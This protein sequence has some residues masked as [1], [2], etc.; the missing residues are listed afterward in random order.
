M[1]AALRALSRENPRF[2]AWS[3]YRLAGL[4]QKDLLPDVVEVLTAPDVEFGLR[5][6]VLQALEG[7]TL[8]SELSEILTSMVVDATA[9]FATRSEAGE[10]LAG[11]DLG[12]DWSGIV[13][14]LGAQNT[15]D[16]VRLASELMDDVGFDRFSDAQILAVSLSM[17]SQS[18]RAVGVYAGLQ[19]NLPDGRIDA[20]L[21]GIA[22]AAMDMEDRRARPG[23]SAITDLAFGLLARRLA[24]GQLD[25]ETVWTWM[26]PF[27]NGGSMYRQSRKTVAELLAS[28]APL[29]Q[30][31][32]RHVLLD[33]PGDKNVWQRA[34]RLNERSVG[35]NP[36]E[37]DILALLEALTDDDPRWRDVVRLAAHSDDKGETVRAA[38]ARFV[39]GDPEG[40]SWLVELPHPEVP[41]WEL[42]EQTRRRARERKRDADWA[43]HRADFTKGI[44]ALRR[45][46]YGLT[47]GPAKAYLKLFYDMGDDAT[48]GPGRLEEWLGPEIRDACL[49]GFEAFLLLTPPKPT[50]TEIAASYAENRRWEAGYIIT[51]ALG[52]RLRTGRGFDDL[53]DERLMAGLFEVRHTR[54]DD[55]AGLKGLDTELVTIVRRRGIWE[56]AQRLYFETQ[57][58]K[59]R[60]HVDGLYALMRDAADAPLATA[61]AIEWLDRFPAMSSETELELLDHLLSTPKGRDALSLLVPLRLDLDGLDPDR[62]KTWETIGLILRFE[63]TRAALEGSEA[64]TPDHFWHL[65]AR[66]RNDRD[67][68]PPPRLTAGQLA[69]MIGT[70]RTLLPLWHRPEGVTSGDDNE[71]DASEFI[72]ALVNRLG[73]DVSSEAMEGLAALRDGPEDGYT[74]TLRVAAAEQRRKRVEADWSPPDLATI[75]TTVSDE[76]PT[77][78]PQLQAILL[79]ELEVIQAELQG[80]D[81]DWYRDFY[82]GAAPRKEDDC[83]NSILKMLRPLPFDIQAAP[84]GHLADDKRADIMCTLGDLMVPIEVK[85]QWHPELW[86]AADKQLDRLYVNDWRAERGIYLVLWFGP[87]A[88]KRPMPPPAGVPP[89]QTPQALQAALT[90]QSATTRE[91]RN[92]VV[93]LDLT[94]PG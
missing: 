18:D 10:R 94:R 14:Q 26:R 59:G 34:W 25:A 55:H 56:A 75:A 57:V 73:D 13:D 9:V 37:D 11:L 74:D 24:M 43:K 92:Q 51:A 53:T 23:Y 79:E 88:S 49:E 27:D 44:E 47:L 58:S 7:S 3:R 45:G 66:L 89:P 38:A 83:R 72:I 40:E 33:L 48:D 80:S 65:R 77:T 8:V 81:V 84:E 93:V 4:V 2:R 29:R 85:G 36:T 90:A 15:A 69:W 21:S 87:G 61:L 82:D 30:A 78:S 5:L 63:E 76:K 16:S 60:P 39:V 41:E 71:W 54:V 46:D 64:V 91:G 67:G 31:I 50:A 6:L 20:L 19:R 70:F 68:R 52:E 12:T 17:M 86:F 35:L 22:S 42:K 62:R 32:Q 1:F 28:D